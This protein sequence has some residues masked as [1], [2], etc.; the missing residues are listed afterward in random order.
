MNERDRPR[1]RFKKEI[2][3]GYRKVIDERYSYDN[4]KQ[5]SDLP[6]SFTKER[7]DLFKDYF[8]N[9]LYPEP[10]KREELDDAFESLDNYIKHPEKLFPILKDSTSLIFKYGRHLPK[11]LRAG[12]KAL[13][14][15]RTANRFELRLVGQAMQNKIQPPYDKEMIY[16]LIGALKLEEIEEFI[17]G[18]ESL[19]DTL[20]DR[21]L[22][23]K[24]K[25]IV[26]HLLEKMRKKPQVYSPV[27][28]R[29]LEIGYDIIK[30]GDVLFEMLSKEEQELVLSFIVKV[31]RGIIDQIF[32]NEKE[33]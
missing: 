6:T 11:I 32:S 16:K 7:I 8:L 25:E 9:Y 26:I 29:G 31:E 33:D 1:Y 30:E 2:I 15:F 28:I 23:A 14:A 20:H 10:L 19:F 21:K 17:Q 18:S 22:V 13:Q 27:E 12:L 5:F 3:I 4:L 24:I